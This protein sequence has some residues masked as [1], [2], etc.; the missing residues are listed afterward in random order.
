MALYEYKCS[1]CG[2]RYEKVQSMNS[3]SDTICSKCYGKVEKVL[4]PS[5][6]QFKGSGWY[7]TDYAGK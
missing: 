1:K 7:V 4:F 6:L 2:N 5:A 3:K